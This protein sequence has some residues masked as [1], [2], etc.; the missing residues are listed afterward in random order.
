MKFTFLKKNELWDG[1]GRTPSGPASYLCF[2]LDYGWVSLWRREVSL[3]MSISSKT[4]S[5]V[6]YVLAVCLDEH[7]SSFDEHLCF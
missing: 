3:S 4:F 5:L 6:M 1:H 7:R 2:I